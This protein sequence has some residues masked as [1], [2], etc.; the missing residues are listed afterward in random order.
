M[1]AVTF[2]A[3]DQQNVDKCHQRAQ[4]GSVAGLVDPEHPD[5]RAMAEDL[6]AGAVNAALSK[7]R[8]AAEDEF[9]AAASELGLPIPPGG[10]GGLMGSD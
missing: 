2:P 1:Q 6:I 4:H 8:K 7:A 5:D 10:L 3:K 9:H